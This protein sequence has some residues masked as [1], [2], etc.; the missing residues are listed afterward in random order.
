MMI[1]YELWRGNKLHFLTVEFS[2]ENYNGSR[3]DPPYTD[4]NLNSVLMNGRGIKK[5]LTDEEYAEIKDECWRQ[6]YGQR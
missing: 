2:I 5:F 3:F 1:D 6:R 4:V